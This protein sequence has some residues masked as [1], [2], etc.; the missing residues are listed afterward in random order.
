MTT[1]GMLATILCIVLV[2]AT[3]ALERRYRGRRGAM[4]PTDEVFRDPT[5]GT[6]TRVWTDANDNRS[7][8]P[9]PDSR[10]TP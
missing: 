2:A 8:R 1:A 10:T 6:V 7:Y 5:A 3:F 4:R 9:D